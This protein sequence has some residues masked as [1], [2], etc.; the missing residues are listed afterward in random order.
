MPITYRPAIADDAAACITLRTQTRENAV[1]EA[2]LAAAGITRETWAAGIDAGLY[3]GVVAM[4]GDILAGYCFAHR[5]TGEI[6]VLALLPDYEGQGVGKALLGMAVEA[7]R[8]R[9]FARVFLGCATD[10]AVRSYGFYRHLGWRSTG[11][12]NDAGDEVLEYFLMAD[13]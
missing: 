10:P 3:P 4:D 2:E 7:L 9:G 1:T 12:F 6:V 5:D 11:T 8:T 13:K